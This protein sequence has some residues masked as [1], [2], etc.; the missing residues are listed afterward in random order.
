MKSQA[1][2]KAIEE[3]LSL[4]RK[5]LKGIN[6]EEIEDVISE[7]RSHL[8]E[9]FTEST[10]IDLPSIIKEMGKPD[11]LAGHIKVNYKSKKHFL[12]KWALT[13]FTALTI[14]IIPG[15]VFFVAYFI[16]I[17]FTVG[18]FWSIFI[19]TPDVTLRLWRE[20]DDPT[21]FYIFMLI[22]GVVILVVTTWL[23]VRAVKLY[24]KLLN[25]VNSIFD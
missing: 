15:F 3:Y 21:I 2:D 20:F 16:G 7:I 14:G 11:A 4:L 9:T 18:A 24:I 22:C 10:E 17:A 12:Y 23:F 5:E 8:C 13:L 1:S 6:Q 25:K 19:D